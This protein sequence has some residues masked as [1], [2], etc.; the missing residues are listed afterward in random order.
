MCG[1]AGILA[2]PGR[3]QAIEPAAVRRMGEAIAHRGP[4][5]HGE[6]IDAERGIALA[7]RR[8]AVVDLSAAGH[9]PMTSHCGRYVVVYNGEIYNHPELRAELGDLPWRGHSDT[10]T[11]LA[12]FTRHGVVESLPRLVGM[13]AIAVWDREAATLTLAR[14]RMGEKPVYWGALGDQGIA[15]GSELRALQAHP[16]WRGEVDR[17]ALALLMRHNCI[18]APH[19]I[20]RGVHKLE[21]ASWLCVQRDGSVRQGRYWDLAQ[22]SL[23][24][25]ARPLRL[26]DTEA[27]DRLEHLLLDTLRGQMLADVPLGAFLSGGVDSS[28]IVAL[29]ARQS[30]Q[31]VRTFCVG[32]DDGA[33]SEA[34]HAREVARHLGTDHTEL[35]VGPG[36]A[37]ALVPKLATLYDEPFADSSQIPTLLVA[38]MARR[39]VTVALSGDAGDE[40][41][42]GY[43]RH[44][45]A[46]RLWPRLQRTPL[47]LRRGLAGLIG[48]V[49]SSTWDT[50]LGAPQRL[51]PPAR[52]HGDVGAKLHKLARAVLPAADLKSLYR[53]LTSHWTH[54]NALVLDAREPATR[55]DDSALA[56]HWRDAV[57]GMS[58][59]DQLTYLPDD[60]LVKVDRAA[61][62]H[63]LETRAPFLDHRL[64]EFS[65]GLPLHQKIR[66]GQ[67]KWL[68]RQVLYRHVPRALIERPKQGFAVPLDAWLRGPLRDWAE[69]L[70]APERLQREGYV[71]IAPV[72]QAWAEH[73]SGRRN[74]AP[75]LWDVLMF[76]AWLQEQR[77]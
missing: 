74:R 37:L 26:S 5:D 8:L 10:E 12:L 11:L 72:R 55:I 20:W 33:T 46:H 35:A 1:I 29:M 4:D 15:F 30:S 38:Q 42:A 32:F 60:I 40:L 39:H 67:T 7:H 23:E 52:R 48:S 70:L 2:A 19:S 66:H 27:T 36:D 58:I 73:Q 31:K 3:P 13:F 43:N 6:W 65:W 59:T 9:Q 49:S 41:F 24:A 34:V 50:L 44:L 28:T 51:L 54:P 64:V 62:A 68:L 14:D 53:A 17:D 63:S 56:P 45:I 25:M 61:M 18:P 47:G 76:Q 71:A 57:A 16:G 22:R 69:A 77:A 75:E 21:P